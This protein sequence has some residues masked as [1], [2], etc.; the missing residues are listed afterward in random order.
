MTDGR[1]DKEAE[2]LQDDEAIGEG[3]RVEN[4]KA[5]VCKGGCTK[6]QGLEGKRGWMGRWIGEGKRGKGEREVEAWSEGGRDTL[7][8]ECAP[9]CAREREGEREHGGEEYLLPS[10]SG[11]GSV[12]DMDAEEATVSDGW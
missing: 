3:T 2:A 6:L 9:E 10:M 5:R 11:T 7:K 8:M 12:L 4:D 1:P